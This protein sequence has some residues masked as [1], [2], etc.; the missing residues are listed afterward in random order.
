MNRFLHREVVKVLLLELLMEPEESHPASHPVLPTE[1]QVSHHH[2]FAPTVLFC[3]LSLPCYL[4]VNGDALS[5]VGN[6]AARGVH[7]T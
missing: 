2:G 7:C 1:S 3:S 5:K 6:S 4:A